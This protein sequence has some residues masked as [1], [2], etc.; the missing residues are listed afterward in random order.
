MLSYLTAS[1]DTH[2]TLYS[3]IQKLNS[4]V[5]N[6]IH[7]RSDITQAL[8]F[9][10]CSCLPWTFNIGPSQWDWKEMFASDICIHSV[11]PVPIPHCHYCHNTTP[12]LNTFQLSS[13]TLHWRCMVWSTPHQ[14]CC[15]C[16][17]P[18]K[19]REVMHSISSTMNKM[20][21]FTFITVERAQIKSSRSE[22]NVRLINSNSDTDC[23]RVTEQCS[24]KLSLAW[25]WC[26]ICTIIIVDIGYNVM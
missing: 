11:R 22:H 23:D 5:C 21:R 3:H 24:V 12:G 6:Y 9:S 26:V 15:K 10:T 20:D 1:C 4:A 7:T 2:T 19:I 16:G 14:S 25:S 17:L 18:Y 13:A 8:M